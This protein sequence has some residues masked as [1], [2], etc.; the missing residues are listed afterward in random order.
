MGL[1][2]KKDSIFFYRELP[3]SAIASL[4]L[5]GLSPR[6]PNTTDTNGL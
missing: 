2:D 4:L 3:Q 1:V 5:T 6:K